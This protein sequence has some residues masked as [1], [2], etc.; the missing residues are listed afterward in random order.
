[1]SSLYWGWGLKPIKSS[2]E[3]HFAYAKDALIIEVFSMNMLSNST[4]NGVTSPT[5]NSRSFLAQ[6]KHITLVPNAGLRGFEQIFV[7]HGTTLLTQ[8]ARAES[9]YFLLS[10]W[11]LEEELTADGDVAW[12]DI[13]MRGEVAGLNC[14]MHEHDKRGQYQISTASILAL[15]DVL[16]VRLPRSR[17]IQDMQDDRAFSKVVNDTLRCQTEHL[18]SHLVALSAKSAHDRVIMLLRS[19]YARARHAHALPPSMRL[20]ISQ[21]VLA[22]VA[23]ISVVHMNR[24]AQKL[25]H[26]GFLDWTQEG[27]LINV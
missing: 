26:D 9:I 14:A 15:T 23:N 25:R 19:F 2:D 5:F 21:V 8:G 10:G 7:P 17:V 22:R 27:V 18:H 12:A 11:A 16:A 13:M 1:M 20:P 3:R 4:R 24:I 6:D